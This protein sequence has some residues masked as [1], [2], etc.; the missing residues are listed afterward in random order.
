MLTETGYS[1]TAEGEDL[2]ADQTLRAF[3]DC[4]TKWPEVLAILP[5]TFN[6]PYGGFASGDWVYTDSGTDEKGLPTKAH[7]NYWA[8]YKLA[9]PVDPWGAISGKITESKFGY[10]IKGAKVVLSTG[11]TTV[12]DSMGNYWF[13]RL[14]PG[15]YTIRA[16]SEGFKPKSS[17]LLVV[18]AGQNSVGN[19]SL[20]AIKQG[21]ITGVIK[22][23]VTNQGLE[24]VK[25][26]LQ[27]GGFM[28]VTDAHGR[29]S[30]D[31]IP[32]SRYVLTAG[33]RGFYTVR[34]EGIS[35]KPGEKIQINLTTGPGTPPLGK[36]LLSE[37]SF[38]KGDE[39]PAGNWT[40]W[41]EAQQ[42]KALMVDRTTCYTGTASQRIE[43]NGSSRNHVWQ[44]TNYS[45]IEPGKTYRIEVWAKCKDAVGEVKLVGSFF[46][47]ETVEMGSF[48][49]SPILSGTTGWTKLVAIGTAPI[50]PEGKKGRLQV[51]VVADLK[52]GVAWFDEAWAGRNF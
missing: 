16:S 26:S 41:E 6:D 27:P 46:T 49:G 9:K 21:T 8:V 29:Y 47:N 7:G 12:T 33:K 5:F 31:K 40:I 28:S 45:S 24:G 50:F 20:E 3:R 52:S 17:S 11:E 48:T 18:S 30:F 4:W 35:V 1:L 10:P 37:H 15:R 32:P 38:E 19:L 23:A 22:D 13:P 14:K 36:N 51:K 39:G 25:V 43:P 2:L 34:H 42:P 44:M